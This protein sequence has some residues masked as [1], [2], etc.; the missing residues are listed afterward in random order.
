MASGVSSSL[1]CAKLRESKG[2][3]STKGALTF[4]AALISCLFLMEIV[5]VD[6]NNRFS[7]WKTG[8]EIEQ[9]LN[10]SDHPEQVIVLQKENYPL[11][12]EVA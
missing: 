11:G 8:L 6:S 10:F 2:I 7:F 3:R 9:R 5:E 1:L 4:T 12:R